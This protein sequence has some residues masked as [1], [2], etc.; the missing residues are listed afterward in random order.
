MCV[1]VCVRVR[2]CVCARARACVGGWG[3]DDLILVD[4]LYL[5]QQEMPCLREQ[6]RSSV[7]LQE[8]SKRW[9]RLGGGGGRCVCF[10]VVAFGYA[11]TF[12]CDDC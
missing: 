1:C 2:V 3:L 9:G 5:V 8:T 12:W 6:T 4:R 10:A 7:Y 11:V